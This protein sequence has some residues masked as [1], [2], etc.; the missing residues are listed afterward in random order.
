MDDVSKRMHRPQIILNVFFFACVI[1]GLLTY[2][3]PTGETQAQREIRS[4]LNDDSLTLAE[5]L[6]QLT[7][8]VQVGSTIESVGERIA[9][10]PKATWEVTRPTEWTFALGDVNLVL[11]IEADGRVTAIGKHRY[12]IDDGTLWLAP[13]PTRS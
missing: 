4:I 10:N 6:K 7:P 5:Q 1:G 12:Q 2:F 8:Y 9:P 11:F 13:P 3:W